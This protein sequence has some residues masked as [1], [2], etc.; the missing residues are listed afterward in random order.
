MLTLYTFWTF[1]IRTQTAPLIFHNRLQKT[2]P[3]FKFD[4]GG[5]DKIIFC[6]NPAR[7]KLRYRLHYRSSDV[8]RREFIA[9][10][11]SYAD[12]PKKYTNL[13]KMT[14]NPYCLPTKLSESERQGH[15]LHG[16]MEL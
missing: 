9:L 2:M 10:A 5:H 6:L 7:L 8:T 12:S 14:P 15:F 11:E 16:H 4:V 13:S 3:D 1:I